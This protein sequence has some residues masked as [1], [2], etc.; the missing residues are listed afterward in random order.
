MINESRINEIIQSVIDET[1]VSQFTPYTE[2]EKERNFKALRGEFNR[3][4]EDRNPSY[5]KAVRA[6][7]ERMRNKNK[8]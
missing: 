7:Q 8:K 6:A 3:S 5:M 1:V 2:D 4:L